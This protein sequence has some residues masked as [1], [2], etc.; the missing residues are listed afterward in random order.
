MMVL[1]VVLA[2]G[3]A[4]GE[5]VTERALI[6]GNNQSPTLGRPTLQYADDDAV[7]YRLTYGLMLPASNITLLTRFDR[8]TEQL[9]PAEVV[10]SAAPTRAAVVAAFEQL[11]Q[12]S[13]QAQAKHERFVVTVIF[14]G[15][16][17]VNEGEGF[18]ELEDGRLSAAELNGWLARINADETRLILD[19]CNSFAMVAPRKPGGKRF[20]TPKELASQVSRDLPKVGVFLSTSANAESYEWSELQSG[21]FS[22]IVRSGLAD[23]AD[24]NADGAITYRELR[25]FVATAAQSVKNPNLRPQVLARGPAGDDDRVLFRVGGRGGEVAISGSPEQALRVSF[26]DSNGIR[27][28]DANF[29][30]GSTF[31]IHIPAVVAAG[32]VVHSSAGDQTIPDGVAAMKLEALPGAATPGLS[33]RGVNSS[34]SALFSKPFGPNELAALEAEAQAAD[35]LPAAPSLVGV[36]DQDFE[37]LRL[38][39]EHLANVDASRRRVNAAT[40]LSLGAVAAGV[41]I[42]STSVGFQHGP[43]DANDPVKAQRAVSGLGLLLG[44]VAEIG[45]GLGSL[46]IPQPSEVFLRNDW[47]SVSPAD[48]FALVR[49]A[50]DLLSTWQRDDEAQRRLLLP[51]GI[52]AVALGVA[53]V[54]L[55][56]FAGLSASELFGSSMVN[57]LT[58]T[59]AVVMIT[60]AQLLVDQSALDPRRH[61]FEQWFDGKQ[62]DAAALSLSPL[63]LPQ[64]VGVAVSGHL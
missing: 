62:H 39:V 1:S 42:A 29:A 6:I 38:L 28:V 43:P 11:V 27:W 51:T 3:G 58:M 35:T 17:D 45:F 59:G 52:F 47:G 49:R 12:T 9:T 64:G 63:I 32:M 34:L 10:P 5:P 55:G 53:S 7:R 44:S 33:A 30:A 19:S 14:A 31:V 54:G 2:L 24:A 20:S 40:Q 61:L 18:I 22:H 46:L 48:R 60:G 26:Q 50:E 56:I 41:G 4:V 25:G 21:I 57:L 36:S 23:A 13:I 8:D 37:K 16:G 15:H